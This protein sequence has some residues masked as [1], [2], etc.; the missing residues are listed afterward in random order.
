MRASC[1]VLSDLAL[2]IR[3]AAESPHLSSVRYR[4]RRGPRAGRWN[5]R[6]CVDFADALSCLRI[7]SSTIVHGEAD[8]TVSGTH[9]RS[10]EEARA[11]LCN[12]PYLNRIDDT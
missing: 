2:I 4:A 6:K 1:L 8:S 7:L 3:A 10:R 5:R 11:S 12:S 9:R